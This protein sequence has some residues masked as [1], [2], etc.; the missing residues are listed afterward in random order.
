M[1]LKEII[2]IYISIIIDFLDEGMIG[3][4]SGKRR[5]RDFNVLAFTDFDEFAVQYPGGSEIAESPSGSRWYPVIDGRLTA[6][7]AGNPGAGKSYLAKEL[8]NLLPPSSE[9]LLFTALDEKDG[10]FQ[11]FYDEERIYKI[12]MEPDNLERITLPAI[13]ER[14][15]N[16]ILLFDDIDK[17]RDPRVSKLTFKILED[18]LANGRGHRNH[19]GKGDIHTIVTSH[20]L[21]DY[22][23]TK[24]S[25]ENSD[26]V[27]VFPQSTTYAQ[28]KRLFEKIG[29]DKK[30]CD[31][32]IALGKTGKVRS[33]II[34]KTAPMYVIAGSLIISI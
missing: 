34:K 6:F 14:C 18:A 3:V 17:I 20:S 23:K 33:V 31:D 22:L 19:D 25:L 26:F 10:N 27:C 12:R 24:Y 8:I 29:L 4:I 5:T 32:I 1:I 30:M 16:P 9:I 28:M 13:R 15:K 11:E 7:I 2:K 21:N